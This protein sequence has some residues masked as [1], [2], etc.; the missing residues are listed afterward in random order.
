[1]D[2]RDGRTRWAGGMDRR[3]GPADWRKTDRGDSWAS[4]WGKGLGERA[5]RAAEVRPALA[6]RASGPPAYPSPVPPPAPPS[7]P[8]SVSRTIPA[9]TRRIR[10]A[11][12][13]RS[14]TPMSDSPMR[15]A[16]RTWSSVSSGPR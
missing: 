6:A 11:P 13:R 9:S 1:M 3:I 8:P 12:T 15:D 4:G 2:G 7:V 10:R 5:G 14:F 16:E